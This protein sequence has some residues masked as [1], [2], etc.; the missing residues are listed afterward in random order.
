M[1]YIILLLNI[2]ISQ[3]SFERVMKKGIEYHD[4]GEY[5]K[6][7]EMYQ[8]AIKIEPNNHIALYELAL[9]YLEKK[10]YKNAIKYSEKVLKKDSKYELQSIIILGSA[11]DMSG[12]MKKSVS[13]FKD[14]IK[15]YGELGSLCFNLSIVLVKLKKYEEAEEY[16]LKGLTDNITHTSS[17]L[18]LGDLQLSKGQKYKALFSYIYFLYLEPNT[19][20]SR[21]TL[22]K[23]Q[24]L[25]GSNVEKESEG[26]INIFAN[27]NSKDIYSKELD[28]IISLFVAAHVGKVDEDNEDGEEK[29]DL[30][31]QLMK[32]IFKAESKESLDDKVNLVRDL[33]LPKFNRLVKSEYMNAFYLHIIQSV[34]DESSDWINENEDKYT[35]FLNW[36]DQE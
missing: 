6:A 34:S 18:M 12:K 20:R 24:S 22:I 4:A 28:I 33:Y 2:V 17:H 21:N 5:D 30:L 29:E 14:G 36:F 26:K 15:K 19:I 10:D 23:I 8:E 25:L 16:I 11:L 3:T 7:I 35:E 27:I 32:I 31:L 9:T 13:V 1:I